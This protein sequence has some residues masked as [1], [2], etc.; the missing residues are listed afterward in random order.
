MYEE[1]P[2]WAEDLRGARQP[3]D[4]PLAAGHYLSRITALTGVPI[5][6]ASVGPEREQIVVF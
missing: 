6:M 4:L 3:D 1:A 5:S 2:G